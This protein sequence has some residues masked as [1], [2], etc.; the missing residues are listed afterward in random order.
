[1]CC[2]RRYFQPNKATA[3][4]EIG[5]ILGLLTCVKDTC[6]FH[7]AKQS[8]KEME[9]EEGQVTLGVPGR[10]IPAASDNDPCIS[11]L[12]G[13]PVRCLLCNWL[14]LVAMRNRS[15]AS[16]VESSLRD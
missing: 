1:V 6:I 10:R 3:T 14:Q 7:E 8:R 5:C 16:A 15:F 4:L 11:K 9:A 13:V 12:G 2:K